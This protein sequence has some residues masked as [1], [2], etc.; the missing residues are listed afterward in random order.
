MK[1]ASTW[2]TCL[3]RT[4]SNSNWWKRKV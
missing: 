2:S 1:I 4:S 3:C